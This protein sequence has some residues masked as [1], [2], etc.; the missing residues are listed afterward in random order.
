MARSLRHN[1]STV[2]MSDRAGER[3]TEDVMEGGGGAGSEAGG[4]GGNGEESSQRSGSGVQRSGASGTGAQGRTVAA[5]PPPE[6]G[7]QRAR[8]PLPAADAV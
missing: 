4:R 3:L 6:P 8:L 5:P 2:V 7:P 1:K